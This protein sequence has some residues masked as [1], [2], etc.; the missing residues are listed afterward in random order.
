MVL[1]R[2]LPVDPWKCSAPVGL[3][4]PLVYLYENNY[5]MLLYAIIPFLTYSNMENIQETLVELM[6]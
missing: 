4:R 3:L 5:L 2:L 6:I 1:S